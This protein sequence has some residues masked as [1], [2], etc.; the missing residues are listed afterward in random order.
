MTDSSSIDRPL[1]S[2]I[3]ITHANAQ[4]ILV[5]CNKSVNYDEQTKKNIFQ[6]RIEV[7]NLLTEYKIQLSNKKVGAR[8][9]VF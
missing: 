1:T 7:R 4:V 2:S 5:I 6:L 3:P 9:Q 8:G